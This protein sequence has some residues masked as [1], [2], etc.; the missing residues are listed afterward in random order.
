VTE[1]TRDPQSNAVERATMEAPVRQRQTGQA[2]MLVGVLLLLFDLIA[3]TFVP[4]DV[5]AGHIL[6]TIIF[7]ADV[8]AAI[9]L[10]VIGTMQR[11]KAKSRLNV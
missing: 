4:S 3:V 8:V 5:R 10:I 1:E 9:T 11:A 7:A 2:L 6:W